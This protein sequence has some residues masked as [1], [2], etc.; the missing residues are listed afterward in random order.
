MHINPHNYM[1]EADPTKQ[2]HFNK[3]HALN[4]IYRWGYS[5]SSILQSVLAK[6]GMSWT[7]SAIQN[8]WLRKDPESLHANA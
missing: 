5:T 6:Q 1:S 7:T 8:G 4:W 3:L 2:G